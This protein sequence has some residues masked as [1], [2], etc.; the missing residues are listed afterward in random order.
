MSV[1]SGAEPSRM[2]NRISKRAVNRS[3]MT[4]SEV[5]QRK[6]EHKDEEKLTCFR[7]KYE[8][9]SAMKSLYTKFNNILTFCVLKFVAPR[10]RKY[11]WLI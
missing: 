10:V 11:D 9:K 7:R 2:S 5:V 3:F 8:K 1:P 4:L 6:W